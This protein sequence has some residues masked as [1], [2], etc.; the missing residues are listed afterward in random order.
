[1]AAGHVDPSHPLSSRPAHQS[2]QSSKATIRSASSDSF[3]STSHRHVR[4]FSFESQELSASATQHDS[5]PLAPC[6]FEVLGRYTSS[7]RRMPYSIEP[8]RLGNVDTS[9]ITSKFS[10]DRERKLTTNMREL[11]DR[12]LPTPEVEKKRQKLVTKLQKLLN[13]ERPEHNFR[14]QLFGSSGNLLCL[15]DS[16]VGICITTEWKKFNG[17]YGMEKVTCVSSEKVP[18]VKIWD[19]ELKLACDMTVNGIQALQSTLMVRAYAEIGPRV[20][21]LAMIIKYWTRRRIIGDASKLVI[22]DLK[23]LHMDTDDYRLPSIAKSPI[24]PPLHSDGHKSDFTNDLGT[25]CRFGE[26]NKES[27]GYLLFQFFKFYAHDFDYGKNVLSVRLGKVI[28]KMQ[29]KWN[30][31]SNNML[32]VEEPFNIIGNRGNTAD[33]TAFRGLHLELRGL[34]FN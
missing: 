13:D 14:A 18:I 26:H 25:L 15:D 28:T 20:R 34:C 1:M 32:C 8:D 11:Y 12:V 23:F 19:P 33:D 16:D 2:T 4:D 5:L 6:M 22:W 31:P 9:R 3:T 10:E 21:P 29:K 30:V 7:Q 27:L 17:V 24:L